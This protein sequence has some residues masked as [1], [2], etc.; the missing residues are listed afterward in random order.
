MPDPTPRS[1]RI[2]G[3]ANAAPIAWACDALTRAL[4]GRGIAVADD[5]AVTV[6]FASGADRAAETAASAAGIVL[7]RAA[8]AMALLPT[9]EGVLAWGADT[10]GLVYALTELADRV[11]YGDGDLFGALPLVEQPS[12]PIRS[13]A[14]LFCSD[15]EDKSWFHDRQ[16][17]HDYLS[18][19]ASNRFNRFALTLGMGY[20]YPYHNNFITDVYFYFPYPFLLEMPG[21]GIDVAEL[22]AE[23]RD[24]NL[25]MLKFIARETAR[26]RL[27][28]PHHFLPSDYLESMFA[29]G[30]PL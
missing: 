7:P 28:A 10:R 30:T 27:S 5:A 19:L 14:R 23:E 16:H 1:I 2:A 29:T 11:R 24:A 17:W 25:A 13:I 3:D 21:F 26:R 6:A 15:V 18:M 8:E 9:A 22:S 12:A 20:N 4:H